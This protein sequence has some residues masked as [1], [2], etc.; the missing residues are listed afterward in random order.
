MGFPPACFGS[1]RSGIQNRIQGKE[2]TAVR[3]KPPQNKKMSTTQPIRDRKQLEQFKDY[4]RTGKPNHRNYALILLGLN[5]A[6]RISDVLHLTLENVYDGEKV[7]KHILIRERKTGKENRLLL[8]SRARKVLAAYRKELLKTKMY[9][10]GN[11]YLFPSARAV[12]KPL[13]RFQAYRI[14]RA[15]AEG[16]GLEDTV[17]CH[18]LRKTFG[19][20]AWK[21]G[22]DPIVIMVLFN[23]SSLNI[24]KRYLCLEQ[25][26]KD[27]ILQKTA[28]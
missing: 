9:Q 12:G 18:S 23:H 17:S 5:T 6:L 15:A 24:T 28:V 4:Y 19:Y 1:R 27:A 8:N 21:Q 20:H 10:S 3:T 13:S 2:R 26:D 14:I 11:P 22:Q 7:R 25:D 16:V